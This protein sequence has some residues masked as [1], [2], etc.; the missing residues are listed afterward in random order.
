MDDEFEELRSDSIEEYIA[1]FELLKARIDPKGKSVWAGM[2]AQVIFNDEPPEIEREF[3]GTG[4]CHVL[5]EGTSEALEVLM[6][7][8][9]RLKK[10]SEDLPRRH[11]WAWLAIVHFKKEA[12]RFPH[13]VSELRKYVQS[14]PDRYKEQPSPEGPWTRLWSETSIREFLEDLNENPPNSV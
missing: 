11:A 12:G 13:D 7:E 1:I 3:F 4:L 5:R 2:V 6:R 10:A 9:V 14:R 8:L